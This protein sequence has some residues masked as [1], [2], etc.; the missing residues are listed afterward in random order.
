MQE[1]RF[2]IAQPVR[3]LQR[4]LRLISSLDSNIPRLIPDGIFGEETLEAVMVFQRDYHLPVT[5]IVDQRSWDAIVLESQRAEREAQS[6]LM[7]D[8]MPGP[9]GG[10]GSEGRY[11]DLYLVQ[12]M[13]LALAEIFQGVIKT[14]VTGTNDLK[15]TQNI[16]WLQKSIEIPETGVVDK[17]TWDALVQLYHI[18]IVHG[19]TRVMRVNQ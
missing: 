1:E 4:M 11:Q 15:T 19:P 12:A 13:F 3:D 9:N 16:R 17:D 14:P 10:I 6:P 5:G 2:Q 8:G 7:I 18:F